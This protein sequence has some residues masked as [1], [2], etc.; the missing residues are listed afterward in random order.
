MSYAGG[1]GY[2]RRKYLISPDERDEQRH[3]KD[4]ILYRSYYDKFR[5]TTDDSNIGTGG[6]DRGKK[7]G[8]G[9]T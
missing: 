1:R 5:S 9:F 4:E 2:P 6:D 3:I 7:T 8:I